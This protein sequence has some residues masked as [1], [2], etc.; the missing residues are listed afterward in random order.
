MTVSLSRQ[1]LSGYLNKISRMLYLFL[2]QKKNT[3][4]NFFRG[5]YR[6]D[7]ETITE[8][9]PV[10]VINLKRN[11][12]KFERSLKNLNYMGLKRVERFI[13]I[14]DII[15]LR[16]CSK[17]HLTLWRHLQVTG[18]EFAVICEDD[19]RFVG[20][21]KILKKVILE[22]L[23]SEKMGMLCL[24]S[25]TSDKGTSI[26]R[27]L[28]HSSSVQAACVY[29]V[30]KSFLPELI[31]YG[32]R[33]ISELTNSNGEKGALDKVWKPLQTRMPFVI[34]KKR[35]CIQYYGYSDIK[36]RRTFYTY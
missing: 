24:A 17:S 9:I 25:Y 19:L 8:D 13:A 30:R 14:E 22:F 35:M 21:L 29:I 2:L 1:L 5:K 18:V 31:P 26:T 23:K 6:K 20:N 7:I 3:F 12:N 28:K 27:N 4:F 10:Y 34:P 16:G 32:E 11:P 33:S 36:K 15:G